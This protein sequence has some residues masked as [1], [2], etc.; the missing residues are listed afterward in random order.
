MA[1]EYVRARLRQ[2]DWD[3]RD[4]IDGMKAEGHEEG[5]LVRAGLRLLMEQERAAS[6]CAEPERAAPRLSGQLPPK[7]VTAKT[8]E[9]HDAG[10]NAKEK[11]SVDNFLEQF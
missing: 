6:I 8:K 9:N 3:L 1:G 11:G 2:R 5:D 4:W 10:A 7:L